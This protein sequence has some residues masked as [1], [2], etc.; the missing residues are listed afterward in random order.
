MQQVNIL[1]GHRLA[2]SSEYSSTMVGD[3]AMGSAARMLSSPR[4]VSLRDVHH[5]VMTPCASAASAH[6][7]RACFFNRAT[8]ESAWT[9]VVVVTHTVRCDGN[10]PNEALPFAAASAPANEEREL[11][12]HLSHSNIRCRMEG[13]L[14]EGARG[15]ADAEERVQCPRERES[16]RKG[17]NEGDLALVQRGSVRSVGRHGSDLANV[18]MTGADRE[19]VCDTV[20]AWPMNSSSVT[21][22]EVRKRRR[23]QAAMSTGDEKEDETLQAHTHV[24][25]CRRDKCYDCKMG[26]YARRKNSPKQCRSMP[27]AG[28]KGAMGH[29]ACN[30]Q[31]DARTKVH[32][33]E[34]VAP[35]DEQMQD[36]THEASATQGSTA[37]QKVGTGGPRRRY[38]GID[39]HGVESDCTGVSNRQDDARAHKEMTPSTGAEC[40]QHQVPIDVEHEPRDHDKMTAKRSFGVQACTLVGQS[41]HKCYECK[42]GLFARRKNSPKQCR[43][44]VHSGVKGAMGHSACNWQDDARS[45][46]MDRASMY[47]EEEEDG[48]VCGDAPN[49][50]MQDLPGASAR[51]CAQQQISSAA[52]MREVGAVSEPVRRRR[53]AS[54]VPRLRHGPAAL[55]ATP[56]PS[57]P[58]GAEDGH[59]HDAGQ[60][61][62]RHHAFNSGDGRGANFGCNTGLLDPVPERRTL[63]RPRLLVALG[64]TQ[65]HQS[66][67]HRCCECKGLM[68]CYFGID[69]CRCR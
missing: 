4:H 45:K 27:G 7:H 59:G 36:V 51:A 3:E 13:V 62:V 66:W 69:E 1:M 29:T 42:F 38:L 15:D 43:S 41:L 65:E 11:D 55:A 61:D 52:E 23:D 44:M 57:A 37:A 26:E 10:R 9:D 19:A 5:A 56:L 33:L 12:T 35:A 30:W 16:K 24:D 49:S 2:A 47:F 63:G 46:D 64:E 8:G 25:K 60:N 68:S 22:S 21:S 17:A 58:P 40:R 39:G 28:V 20:R 50:M 18:E 14:K 34:D 53:L 54:W 67:R 32:L 6:I 31:D 48:G